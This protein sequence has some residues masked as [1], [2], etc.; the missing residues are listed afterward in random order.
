MLP[1]TTIARWLEMAREN[2]NAAF[3]Y[4]RELL[5]VKSL[6][7]ITT[8]CTAHALNKF[9][10]MTKQTKQFADLTH[11]VASQTAEPLKDV[12]QKVFNRVD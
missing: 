1:K 8:L 7:E 10:A 9:D 6:S 4:A 3:D 2:S 11:H 5:D 12:V